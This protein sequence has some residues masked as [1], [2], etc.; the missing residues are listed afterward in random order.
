MDGNVIRE[1]GIYEKQSG[2]FFQAKAAESIVTNN[3]MFNA[4]R[5]GI[6]FNDPFGGGDLITGNLAFSAM[7][8]TKDGGTYNSWDRQP[9]LTTT[10][11]GKPSPF[12]KYRELSLNFLINNYHMEMAIDTDD[13]TS[14][15]R[16][17]HNFLVGGE[18]AL[19]SDQGGHSNWQWENLNA[20]ATGPA[21]N[22][23][24]PQL[25]GMEDRYFNN[26]LIQRN[27]LAKYGVVGSPIAARLPV[28]CPLITVTNTRVFTESGNVS[29]CLGGPSITETASNT[30]QKLPADDDVI[31]WAKDLLEMH[32]SDDRNFSRARNSPVKS[33]MN[34]K[35]DDIDAALQSLPSEH[36]DGCADRAKMRAGLKIHGSGTFTTSFVPDATLCCRAC[37]V[38]HCSTW[39]FGW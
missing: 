27:N 23:F 17:H 35:S 31:T 5:N 37:I 2:W 26:T 11:T 6:T 19:K 13:G 36:G 22:L 3:I 34:V 4:P 38:P 39:S 20:Y 29:G 8:E 32:R 7:R 28:V 18:W 30:V 10:L 33:S 16:A 9:F 12:M 1:I 25:P 24:T 15:M 21:V 14:Y